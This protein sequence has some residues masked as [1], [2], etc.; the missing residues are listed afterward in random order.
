MFRQKDLC[1]TPTECPYVLEEDP[2]AGPDALPC[3]ECPKEALRAYLESPGGQLVSV[4]INL[5]FALQAGITVPLSAIPYTEFL[6]LRQLADERMEYEK[7][8]LKKRQE[9]AEAKRKH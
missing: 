6:L 2:L 5:D 1:P 8:Q 4:V 3:S 7:E 9:E